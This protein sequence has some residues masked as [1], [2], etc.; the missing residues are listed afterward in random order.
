MILR[1][2]QEPVEFLTQTNARAAKSERADDVLV[3]DDNAESRC[4]PIIRHNRQRGRPQAARFSD[5]P[6]PRLGPQPRSYPIFS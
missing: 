6:S 3:L 4:R 5:H 1:E 2:S